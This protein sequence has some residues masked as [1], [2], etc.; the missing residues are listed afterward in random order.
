[1]IDRDPPTV[2]TYH[3]FAQPS[4]PAAK[5]ERSRPW[6][7]EKFSFHDLLDTI[8]PLQHLPVISTIYR[9]LTGD[10]I[11]NVPRIAGDT[12]Y[13]GPLGLVSGL[14][15]AALKEDSG[16]DIGEHVMAMITGD[17]GSKG[18]APADGA[19]AVAA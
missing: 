4:D 18:N 9:W 19:T 8:N 15:G 13:G 5:T 12:L 2:P 3:L 7:G 10:T 11:G 1:M 16:R 6:A 17:D 14:V